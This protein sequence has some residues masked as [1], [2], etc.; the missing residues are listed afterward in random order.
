MMFCISLFS[1]DIWAF[2][3]AHAFSTSSDEALPVSLVRWEIMSSFSIR[4]FIIVFNL[5]S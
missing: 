2:F 3:S 4:I 5:V 1:L